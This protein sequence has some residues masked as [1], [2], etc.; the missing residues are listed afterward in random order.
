M[1]A[2]FLVCLV[3]VSMSLFYSCTNNNDT[4]S[5]TKDNS[6]TVPQGIPAPQPIT[7]T[8]DSVY[9][10]DPKAFTQGLEYL[11]GKIYEGTGLNEQTNIRIVNLK[12]GKPEFNHHITDTS[13]FGEGI[14]IF[15]NKLYQLTWTSH[16]VFVYD[17]KNLNTPIKTLNWSSEG[18]GI[19]HD[20]SSLIVSDGI[21]SN[22]YFVSPDDFKTIKTISVQDNNG[23]VL[24][25]NELE[26]INGY[27]YANQWQTDNILKIDPSNGHVVGILNFKGL[28]DQYAAKDR[29][30]D[31]DVLNGIAYNSQ[32][33]ELYVTGK[34][35]PRLFAI[36]LN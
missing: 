36:H 34:R 30:G 35:W 17:L 9:P 28:L 4:S 3:L 31:T 5:I 16:K 13:I 11:N 15:N 8:V 21:T 23:P 24:N 20:S 2:L 27:L 29:T 19:T 18:W 12:T 6:F 32:T 10:H 14:T 25:L 7:Y 1:K 22:I 33:K 26:L